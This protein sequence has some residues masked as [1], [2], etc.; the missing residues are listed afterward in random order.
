MNDATTTLPTQGCHNC[1]F[2]RQ[3][4]AM[5]VVRCRNAKS[6]RHGRPVDLDERCGVWMRRDSQP[7]VHILR[8]GQP[9]CGF[10]FSL[11]VDWPEGHR[12]V[13]VDEFALVTCAG[14]KGVLQ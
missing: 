2:G 1:E 8:Q 6:P 14:C 4:I 11:P 7:A 13:G 10:T 5:G 12:W 9:V 3:A